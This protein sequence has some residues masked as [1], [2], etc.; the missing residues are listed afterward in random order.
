[1]SPFDAQRIFWARIIPH[2]IL[3]L[4][5]FSEGAQI[6]DD[7]PTAMAEFFGDFIVVNGKIWPRM[8][9]EN[10]KYRLRILNGCDSRFLVLFFIVLDEAVDITQSLTGPM[11]PFDVI[12][13]DQGFSTSPTVTKGLLVEPSSRYDLIID[14]RPFYGN[15]IV[16]MNLGGD[17]PFGGDIPGP[18]V[19]EF[20]DRIMA[21]D[22]EA[23]S[24]G[25]TQDNYIVSMRNHILEHA[26]VHN[27]R[28]VALFEGRDQYGRLMPLLGTVD[29]AKDMFGKPIYWPD[30]PVYKQAGLVGPMQGTAAWHDPTTENPRLGDVEEWEIWNVSADAHPVHLHLAHFQVVR[31]QMIVWDSNADEEGKIDLS[32]TDPAGDGTFLKDQAVVNHDG[33]LGEGYVIQNPTYGMD[34]DPA[35]L[36]GFVGNFPKD[37]G[38]ALPGQ[39]TTIRAQFDKEGAYNWHCHI[40]A[41]EDHEMMRVYYVG[42][43]PTTG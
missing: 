31:R 32:E 12:G 24:D 19:F 9:V 1:M 27:R 6:G 33:S 30:L 5:R 20:T 42:P 13:D 16:M 43:M 10:R 28:R 38:A 40:L 21:F 22:V 4:L 34:V 3:V 14:F 39:I 23:I 35:T 17:E 25:D 41:H 29:P 26:V 18:Q 11:I 15:R 8:C 7:E 2:M 36:Y 37:T